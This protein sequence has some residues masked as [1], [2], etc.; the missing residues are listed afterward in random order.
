[1]PKDVREQAVHGRAGGWAEI[2]VNTV[3]LG[4]LGRLL[5]TPIYI[6]F[7]LLPS[8]RILGEKASQTSHSIGSVDV[9]MR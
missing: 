5:L 9:I 8:S 2:G 6:V 7:R 3:E 1:M 4:R